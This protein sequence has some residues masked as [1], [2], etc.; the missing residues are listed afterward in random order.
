MSRRD[1]HGVAIAFVSTCAAALTLVFAGAATA[2]AHAELVSV[3]PGN[4][5][6]LTALPTAVELVFSEAVGQPADVTVLGPDDTPL[7]TGELTIVDA[8]ASV[9]LEPSGEPAAGWYT[10]SYQ[11]T[12]ADGHP[13]AGT[14]TFMV[15]ASGDTAMPVAAPDPGVAG[16][17]GAPDSGAEPVVVGALVAGLAVTLVVAL[18]AVRRLLVADAAADVGPT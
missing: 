14:S 15:H 13:V 11:V 9:T 2:D 10:I 4:G 17:A 7:P 18:G 8:A 16:R 3:T 1:R 6:M 12:S 5:M